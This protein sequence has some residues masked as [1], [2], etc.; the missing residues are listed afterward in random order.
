M[1]G[2]T[3]MFIVFCVVVL[4]IGDYIWHKIFRNEK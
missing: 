4:A 3:L 1:I 2:D